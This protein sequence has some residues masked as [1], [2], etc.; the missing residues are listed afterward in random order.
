MKRSRRWK[1]Q[2][3]GAREGGSLAYAWVGAGAASRNCER[4][5]L[6]GDL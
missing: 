2:I 4:A 3:S 1:G 6:N 5:R